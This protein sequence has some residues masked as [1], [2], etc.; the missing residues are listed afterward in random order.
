MSD[1]GFERLGREV[2]TDMFQAAWATDYEETDG[3]RSYAVH[4][5]RVSLQALGLRTELLDSCS[6]S[7]SEAHRN[8]ISSG[9]IND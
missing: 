1:V 8:Q 3:N 2:L 9:E 6:T 7:G 4:G 5:L